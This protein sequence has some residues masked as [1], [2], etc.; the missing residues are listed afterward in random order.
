MIL[1][2][3][4]IWK[5]PMHIYT[6][7]KIIFQIKLLLTIDGVQHNMSPFSEPYIIWVNHKVA[8]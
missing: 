2:I 8:H 6:K 4:S 7:Q 1:E 5:N 3:V